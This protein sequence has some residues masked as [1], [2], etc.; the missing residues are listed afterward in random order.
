MFDLLKIVTEATI[1]ELHSLF[2][3]VSDS[4][5]VLSVECAADMS[6]LVSSNVNVKQE[7]GLWLIRTLIGGVT[8]A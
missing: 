7:D 6:F 4:D 5:M 3:S 8:G 1:N 2:I